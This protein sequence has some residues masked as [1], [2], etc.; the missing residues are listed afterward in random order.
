MKKQFI[1]GSFLT[2]L[3]GGLIYVLF[4]TSSLKMFSWYET[5]GLGGLTN[6]LRNWAFQ[7]ADKIPEWILFSLPDGLWIF[8]YVSLMLIIWQNSISLKNIFWILILPFLAISSELGQLFGVI[9]GTF[10]FMDLL[11]Y[12]SGMIL[13][14]IIFTR[15]INITF[16]L[17]SQ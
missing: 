10:D 8:S 12:I 11:L 4:R 17:Q 13:P 16:K 6:E 1:L 15:S 9:I 7:L 5:I 14:L 3:G 2:L